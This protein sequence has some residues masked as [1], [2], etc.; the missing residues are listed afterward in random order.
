MRARGSV[1]DVQVP[2]DTLISRTPEPPVLGWQ[3]RAGAIASGCALAA[4]AVLVAVHDPADAGSR[5]P[6]CVFRS[7]TG[8]WCPGCGLT[9][10]THHL[11]NGDVA[12]TISLNVF[13]PF[14]LFAIVMAWWVWL[15]RSFGHPTRN[16][17]DRA[18]RWFGPS[19]LALFIV[20][21][22]VRNIPIAPFSSLAP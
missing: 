10:A 7:V 4:G 1:G 18:P 20:Y 3:Q 6:A 5:F 9:R 16:L 13:T 12:A 22:V 19:L 17:V 21:G 8:L 2:A 14:V 15:R 11:L